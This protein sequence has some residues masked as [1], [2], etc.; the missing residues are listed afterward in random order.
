MPPLRFR[1]DDE[2]QNVDIK[3]QIDGLKANDIVVG[4]AAI[5]LAAQDIFKVPSANGSVTA[6]D[7]SAS[8]IDVNSLDAQATQDGKTTN[9]KMNAGLKNGARTS[10]GGS[11]QPTDTGYLLSLANAELTRGTLAARLVQPAAIN[12]A[13]SNVSFGD[14]ILDVGQGRVTVSGE[15]AETLNLAV[16][17]QKLPLDIANTIK[18]DLGLGGEINGTAKDRRYKAEAGR[19]FRHAGPRHHCGGAEKSRTRRA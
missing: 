11:L 12:V 10:V 6:S 15:V 8:G 1:H 3:G 18:P 9:F 19:Q 17:I 13:G 16:A 2:K 7:V 4:K 5:A 14:I